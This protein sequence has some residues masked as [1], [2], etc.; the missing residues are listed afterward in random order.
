MFAFDEYE[1]QVNQIADG[2]CIFHPHLSSACLPHRA[3][4]FG[5]HSARL[6]LQDIW[7]RMIPSSHALG[8]AIVFHSGLHKVLIDGGQNGKVG[9]EACI[10]KHLVRLNLE[11]TAFTV[12]QCNRPP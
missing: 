2:T 9:I 12:S 5:G 4:P 6:T 7:G 10:E 11:G 1:G 8:V 3:P